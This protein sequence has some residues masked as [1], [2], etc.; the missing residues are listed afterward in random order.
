MPTTIPLRA[1]KTSDYF[2]LFVLLIA[3]AFFVVELVDPAPISVD[4]ATVA[5][6]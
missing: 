3:A 4:A 6:P 2:P 1:R 5:S